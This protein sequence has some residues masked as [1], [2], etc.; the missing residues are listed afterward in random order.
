M[1]MP[2][3]VWKSSARIGP[4]SKLVLIVPDLKVGSVVDVTV[5]YLEVASAKKPRVP[6]SAK[7]QIWISPD[8]DDPLPE[9]KQYE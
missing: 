8:F 4:G 5:S 9:L 7:G 6:G 3:Y 1:N 2:P